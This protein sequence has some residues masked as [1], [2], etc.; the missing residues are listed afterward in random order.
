MLLSNYLHIAIILMII[1]L[2]LAAITKLDDDDESAAVAII[3]AALS[4]LWPILL[5][6]LLLFGI[7]RMVVFVLKTLTDIE[8]PQWMPDILWG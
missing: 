2:L 5:P 8:Q 7:W 4:W 3:A 6:V 1:A